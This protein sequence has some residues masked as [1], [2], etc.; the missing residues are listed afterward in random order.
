MNDVTMKI[1]INIYLVS[2]VSYNYNCYH[3][4]KISSNYKV[5]KHGTL[6]FKLNSV[7]YL[8]TGKMVL[9]PLFSTIYPSD[10]YKR[11]NKQIYID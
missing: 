1:S 3:Q 2:L 11:I 9:D 5:R 4:I 10:T 8:D 7:Q 6:Y